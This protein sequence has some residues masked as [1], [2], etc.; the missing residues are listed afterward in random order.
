MMKKLTICFLLITLL[1][2]LTVTSHAAEAPD[3]NR[4]ASLTLEMEYGDEMLDSG[5]LTLYRVGDIAKDGADDCFA[6]ISAL[7]DSNVSLEN[8]EDTALPQTLADLAIRHELEAVT[9]SIE[10]GKVTFTQLKP[11]LFVV[12]QQ[13]EEASE[14][15]AQIHPFLISLPHWD[16]EQY[17]YDLTAKPKVSLEPAPPTEP[18][19]TEPPKPTEP[20]EP[21]EPWLPQ[22]GQT[23]WPVPV[24]AVGGIAFIIL[25]GFLCFRKRETHA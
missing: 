17:V 22:T 3:V 12:V 6:L 25:G 2:G 15:F 14:G 19:E 7:D 18:P 16:G 10:D 1:M 5:R 8:L 23:N 21:T 20:T 9:A 11:G 13:D 4:Q 24:M